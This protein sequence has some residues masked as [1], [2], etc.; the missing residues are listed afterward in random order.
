MKYAKAHGFNP[1]VASNWYRIKL[2]DFKKYKVRWGNNEAGRIRKHE[3]RI[4]SFFKK[5]Y[6]ATFY[7]KN[8]PT[9]LMQVFPNIGL[10]KHLFS[11]MS[12]KYLIIIWY[13]T[14]NI[15][16]VLYI[17]L[18]IHRLRLPTFYKM[19]KE[20]RGSYVR[21]LSYVYDPINEGIWVEESSFKCTG[22]LIHFTS[23]NNV[24]FISLI[25]W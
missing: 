1:L 11:S 21:E 20:V 25:I 19:S 12:L 24:S 6:R 16:L 9:M 3:W 23:D 13:P 4:Y 17:N 7:N 5:A 15:L 8:L 22:D 14:L 2:R 10:K 18:P